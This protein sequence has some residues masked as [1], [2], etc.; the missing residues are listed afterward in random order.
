MDE[1]TK[2]ATD[3]AELSQTP[4]YEISLLEADSNIYSGNIAEHLT[5]K[6]SPSIPVSRRN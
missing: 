5:R 3:K 4:C 2:C 6:L 1:G